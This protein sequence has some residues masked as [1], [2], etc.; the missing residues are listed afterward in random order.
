VSI[1]AD[2]HIA[3]AHGGKADFKGEHMS[4]YNFLSAR[5]VSLNVLFVHADFHNPNRLVHGSH[6]AQLAMTVRTSLTGKVFTIEFDAAPAP[7]HKVT[8][9]D[10]DGKV[11]KVVAHGSGALEV[12]NLAVLVREK[13][14]GVLGA[15][16][17]RGAVMLLNTG[18]WLVEA[19]SKPFPNPSQDRGKSLLDIQIIPNYDAD[20][21]VVAPHGLIGQSWDGDGM[22]IDGAQ[23][24]YTAAV[25]TTKAMAEGAIE[26][27]AADYEMEDKFATTFK[28]SRFDAVAAKPRDVTKL[29]GKRSTGRADGAGAGASPDVE[30]DGSAAEGEGDAAE[31]EAEVVVA[32]KAV[33]AKGKALANGIAARAV[34]VVPAVSTPA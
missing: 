34:L 14:H 22:G 12:E 8:V 24:N 9:R 11:V 33:A 13:R 29:L 4:W 10:A 19:A 1:V 15:R 30:T 32:A 2:P 20:H 21:D 17:W 3:F 28:Y 26:G 16:G 27:V 18:R 23:D 5:N 31:V 25:V 7:P 6:M